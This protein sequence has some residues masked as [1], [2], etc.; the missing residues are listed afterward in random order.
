MLK[1]LNGL[2]DKQLT[3]KFLLIKYK[4]YIKNIPKLHKNLQPSYIKNT[5]LFYLSS[6]LLFSSVGSAQ[7]YDELVL[8][9]APIHIQNICK[10][11]K[12]SLQGKS[13]Q[14]AAFNFDGDWDATNNW[15]N[16]ETHKIKPVVYYAVVESR[17]QYFITYAYFH[18][19]D[20]TR[21]PFTKI[22]QHENDLEG[23]IC[24]VEKNDTK[25]GSITA[26]VT[27]FHHQLVYYS[28]SALE[29]LK[30]FN[31][32]DNYVTTQEAKGHGCKLHED[33]KKSNDYFS[34]YPNRH[35]SI[36]NTS[37]LKNDTTLIT[38]ELINLFA[39]N[40]L[41]SQRTNSLFFEKDQTIKGNNGKGANP[42]W[43]WQSNKWK[44]ILP[45][46]AVAK[47]PSAVLHYIKNQN[48]IMDSNYLY[49]P[50]LGIE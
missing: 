35:E 25:F 37:D 12:N 29:K 15:E 18:P 48:V 42:P 31:E 45:A 33:L 2:K 26:V 19:R 10:K 43:L 17:S 13:D 41:W 34:F 32:Q 8:H 38:Y 6:L 21:T 14:L 46:G 3:I 5:K 11:G 28:K 7:N 4:N 24:F 49:N 30:L 47:Y 40:E 23:A 9:Y 39:P 22:G 16:L 20:W 1:S 27:V 44:K 50:Y 36:S